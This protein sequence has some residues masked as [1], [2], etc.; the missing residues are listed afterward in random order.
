M[1]NL[2]VRKKRT[3][4][5]QMLTN[6]AKLTVRLHVSPFY[7]IS[8]HDMVLRP[9]RCATY[10]FVMSVEL[11]EI[12]DTKTKHREVDPKIG[13]GIIYLFFISQ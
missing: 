5:S 3:T 10:P 8:P 12:R 9:N 1:L 4:C 11:L 7:L 6:M 13:L 2:P